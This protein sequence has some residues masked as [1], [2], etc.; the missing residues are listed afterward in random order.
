MESFTVETSA[1]YR[2]NVEKRQDAVLYWLT[3]ISLL[4]LELTLVLGKSCLDKSCLNF[5]HRRWS[6]LPDTAT[7]NICGDKGMR[8]SDPIT[9]ANHRVDLYRYNTGDGQFA[10]LFGCLILFEHDG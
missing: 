8:V 10:V 1:I 6:V 7:D 5:T 3:Y 2:Y 4:S 9:G